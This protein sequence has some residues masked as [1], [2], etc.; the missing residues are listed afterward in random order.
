MMW[1]WATL[2]GLAISGS[3]VVTNAV[4][5][6][7]SH[8]T[9][10]EVGERN[11]HDPAII[12]ERHGRN[13]TST[14]WSGYAVTGPDGSVTDVKGSWKVPDVVCSSPGTPNSYASFWVGIDGYGSNTVEQIGTD[15]DCSGGN[16]V[17]YAWYEFYPH[18]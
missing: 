14:N 17:Y 11:R 7:D 18:Q 10:L 15:S 13:A 9:R 1:K 3:L 12:H 16:A 5:P 8:A 4:L 2:A 6:A